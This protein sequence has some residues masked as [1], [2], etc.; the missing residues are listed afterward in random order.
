LPVSTP[1]AIGENTICP[2]PSFS[3][4]GTISGSITRHSMLYCGWF[5]T[6]RSRPSSAA[7]RSPAA[8][9]SA[10]HSDTPM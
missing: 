4:S 7:T 10:R 5:D 1:C 2:T 3:P 8:I 6:M 9:S